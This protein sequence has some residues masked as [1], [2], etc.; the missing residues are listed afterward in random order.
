MKTSLFIFM[1]F[2][3]TGLVLAGCNNKKQ[4]RPDARIVSAMNAKYPK[5][6]RVEWEQKHGY[7]VADFYDNGM[8]SEAWFDQNGKWLMTESD[9]KY[10]ALP[11]AIKNTFEKSPYSS[12]KK[13]D[14][15]KIERQGMS[16]VYIIEVEKDGQET[17]LYF[18]AGG[19]LVKAL[20]ERERG[21]RTDYMPVLPEIQTQVLQKYPGAA[22]IETDKKG[23]KL[24]V[25]ILDN[26]KPKELVFDHNTWVSTSWKMD[27][28]DVPSAVMDALR[29][30]EYK[31]YR[32]NDVV[33]YESAASSSYRFN[34]E[35][36]DKEVD[37]S[38]DPQGKITRD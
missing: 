26:R 24:Y 27:K 8:E 11:S 2:G 22:I 21:D 37:V 35:Q 32:I 14:I 28:A 13:D 36:G 19:M 10:S 9:V 12:W 31:N 5:A 7:Q 3:M 4:Y 17:D 34:L 30:S 38:I 25:D 29:N 15:D 18:T 23:G 1:L 20:N 16:A 33:F 6:S